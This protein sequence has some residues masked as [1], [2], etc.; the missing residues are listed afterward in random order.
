MKVERQIRHISTK[1]CRLLGAGRSSN[2][3]RLDSETI[4]KKY[5]IHVPVEMIRREMELA[6]KTFVSGIST[7]ISFDLIRVDD[8]YGVVFELID[9]A[10]TIGHT[11]TS[12]MDRFEELTEKYTAL[13]KQVHRIRI[14]E[15]G[16]FPS[17]ADT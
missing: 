6:R 17:V 9:P 14:K 8:A 16:I 13:L 7:A 5:N 4:V 11:I 15:S 2:V 1:N 12:H 10:V 3:Y